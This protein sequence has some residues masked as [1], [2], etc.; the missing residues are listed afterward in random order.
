MTPVVETRKLT[1]FYGRTRGIVDVDLEV[2]PGE[3]FGLL[4]PNGAGKTT[5]IR[6][7][8]DFIRPTSGEARVLGMDCRIPARRARHL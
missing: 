3:V 5:T 1:K 8:L 6:I 4:G 7:L 2:Q